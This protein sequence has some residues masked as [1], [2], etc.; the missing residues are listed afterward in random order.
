MIT[1][2]ATFASY[3][4]GFC[5]FVAVIWLLLAVLNFTGDS[6]SAV[7]N[8]FL[9]LAGAVAFAIS[10]MFIGKGGANQSADNEQA[11]D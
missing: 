11:N 2:G 8:G 10:G 9:W 1:K 7:L 4:K 5:W 6:Q 3:S